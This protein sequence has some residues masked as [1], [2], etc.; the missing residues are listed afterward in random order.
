VPS[1]IIYTFTE[2]EQVLWLSAH[3][4]VNYQ[5]LSEHSLVQWFLLLYSESLKWKQIFSLKK[6][7]KKIKIEFKVD[8]KLRHFRDVFVISTL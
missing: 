7:I 4:S 8:L 3:T 5:K 6:E 2:E 1:I